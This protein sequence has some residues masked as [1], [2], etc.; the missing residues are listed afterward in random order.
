H[1]DDDIGPDQYLDW[2]IEAGYPI[3]RVDDFGEWLQRLE[4]RLR[5]LSE[6]QRRHSLLEMVLQRE[7][8]DL[9]APPPSRERT[10]S[11][12][13]FRAAVQQAQ[14]GATNDIPHVSAPIIL[15]YIT[16]L[17]LLGLL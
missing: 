10:P 1:D 8:N 5:A 17:Q 11:T 9:E 2:V 4:T 13:R 6:P 16:N 14:I 12:D 7:S 15:K 3:E